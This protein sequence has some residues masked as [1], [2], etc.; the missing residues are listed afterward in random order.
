MK[1]K[2]ITQ[3]RLLEKDKLH[4]LKVLGRA[5]LDAGAA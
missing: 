2:E 5:L 3:R 1:K 4:K